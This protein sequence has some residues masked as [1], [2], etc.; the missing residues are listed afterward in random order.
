MFGSVWL[1]S[2]W[3]VKCDWGVPGFQTRSALFQEEKEDNTVVPSAPEAKPAAEPPLDPANLVLPYVPC[4]ATNPHSHSKKQQQQ[5]AKFVAIKDGTVSNWTT[6]FKPWPRGLTLPQRL[7][8]VR[9]AP[10]AIGKK[11]GVGW[12]A[13]PSK[14]LHHCLASPNPHS[15]CFTLESFLDLG[16]L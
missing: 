9:D 12:G 6:N 7:S 15:H 3:R 1:G 11:G 14:G 4:C 16:L 2:L 13:Y 8:R 5:E 10:G